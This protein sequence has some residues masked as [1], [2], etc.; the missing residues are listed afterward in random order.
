MKAIKVLLTI[1]FIS[2]LQTVGFSQII[3]DSSNVNIQ[4][5]VNR[6]TSGNFVRYDSTVVISWQGDNQTILNSDSIFKQFFGDFKPFYETDSTFANFFDITPD[7]HLFDMEKEFRKM[8]EM[9]IR[10]MQMM[11][12]S[13]F[14]ENFDTKPVKPHN[15]K[16]SGTVKQKINFNTIKI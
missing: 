15:K 8:D 11:M 10:Q 2:L 1:L 5:K 16:T 14:F 12:N 3:P 7:K 13:D 9:F 4:I 6:D